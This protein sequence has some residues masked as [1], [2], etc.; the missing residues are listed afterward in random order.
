VTVL[1][2]LDQ[3]KEG[4]T[5][6]AAQYDLLD[7]LVRRKPFSVFLYLNILLYA[8]V[9]AFI[10][11]LGWT[12][13]TYSSQLGDL[14]VIAC[15]TALLGACLGYC[16]YKAL[17]YSNAETPSPHLVFDYIL[18]LGSLV[19]SVELA[20]L[21][22]RFRL[23]SGQWDLYVLATSLLYFGLAYRF[24]NRFVL[25]L[26]LSTLAGWFGLSISHS[27]GSDTAIYRQYAI[28]YSLVIGAAGFGLEW[29]GI[30]RHFL[31]TYLNVA[32]NFLLMA[33]LSGVFNREGF[34]LWFLLLI[35]A[36]I[37]SFRYGLVRKQFAFVAYAAL[38]GYVGVSSILIRN[39]NDGK[40]ILTYFVV[41]GIAMVVLLTTFARRFGR[42]A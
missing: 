6:S 33:V 32:A 8:G 20:Y 11:G 42:E 17:P 39:M 22:N 13:E 15:L 38:Y 23:L 26:A 7:G 18:Y 34:M 4:G 40:A 3:W 10:G 14:V 25:S 21:E 9:L 37:A 1:D 16:F 30:K 31:G 29:R 28:L 5:L 2:R 12:A 36:C 24:D 19:W 35:A 41:T 27:P